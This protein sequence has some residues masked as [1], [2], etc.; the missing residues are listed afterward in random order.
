[1]SI[2]VKIIVVLM[3]S[4]HSISSVEGNSNLYKASENY[5]FILQVLCCIFRKQQERNLMSQRKSKIITYQSECS[6]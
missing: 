6:T 2:L 3:D 4:L 1:M 5:S